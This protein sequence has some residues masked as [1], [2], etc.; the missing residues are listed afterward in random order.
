MSS[1]S[2]LKLK[3][4]EQRTSLGKSTIY[5]RIK[6]GT[7]PPPRRIGDTMSRW[8]SLDIERWIEQQGFSIQ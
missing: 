1:Q 5:R 2:L 6:E 7:F 3:E 4:V 8:N